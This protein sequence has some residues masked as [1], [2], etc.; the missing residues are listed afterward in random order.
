[1]SYEQPLYARQSSVGANLE[2]LSQIRLNA[3]NA[4]FV[5][6]HKDLGIHSPNIGLL[7]LC[8]RPLPI[9]TIASRVPSCWGT[10]MLSQ[11]LDPSTS[12]L[13][14]CQSIFFGITVHPPRLIP[15]RTI[16]MAKH[17]SAKGVPFGKL[18][19]DYSAGFFRD[20]LARY[21]VT[22][23][24]PTFNRNQ[25]ERASGDIFFQFRTVSVFH[26]IKFAIDADGLVGKA[27]TT[28]VDSVHINPSRKDSDSRGRG[29]PARFDTA[30]VTNGTESTDLKGRFLTQL[31]YYYTYKDKY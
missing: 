9:G 25:I 12:P 8:G 4:E 15:R 11:L 17:P 14:T 31:A 26:R 24:H 20:A 19:S 3:V 29:I 16:R 22:L 21:V 2:L 30:L 18:V 10:L 28:V 6:A 23:V 27:P 13:E 5:S 1:M 7:R